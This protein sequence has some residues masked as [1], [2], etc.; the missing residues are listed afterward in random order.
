MGFDGAVTEEQAGGEDSGADFYLF[1]DYVGPSVAEKKRLSGLYDTNLDDILRAAPH[2]GSREHVDL[3]S[4]QNI[5]GCT[6][7]IPDN[8]NREGVRGVARCPLH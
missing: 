8:S 7:P 2:R 4:L 6:L 5:W 3:R 1:A